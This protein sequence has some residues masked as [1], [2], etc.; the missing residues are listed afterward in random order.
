MDGSEKS[1]VMPDDLDLPPEVDHALVVNYAVKLIELI[2]SGKL[3]ASKNLIIPQEAHGFLDT[4]GVL[5]F[6]KMRKVVAMMKLMK[7]ADKTELNKV[8]SEIAGT[9]TNIAAAVALISRIWKYFEMGRPGA[10]QAGLQMDPGEVHML[11]E[12]ELR[13]AGLVMPSFDEERF[14]PQCID[15]W[16]KGGDPKS[17]LAET[18]QQIREVFAQ[19]KKEGHDISAKRV[20]RI[21]AIYG[22]LSKLVGAPKKL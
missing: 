10:S 22:F 12:D 3:L 17:I 9:T 18:Q 15:S 20:E 16:K 14:I 4:E 13:G 8:I 1:S 6:E 11:L 7:V 2:D 5:T 21:S 19:A